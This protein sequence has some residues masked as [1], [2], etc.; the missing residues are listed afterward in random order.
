[1]AGASDCGKVR[2]KNEDRY[3]CDTA[4]QFGILCDGVGGARGGNI[5]AGLAVD[6]LRATLR[7]P[8]NHTA[9]KLRECALAANQGIITRAAQDSHLQ[10]MATT[11]VAFVLAD[12]DVHILHVGDSRAYL[13]SGRTGSLQQLTRDHS[14][15]NLVAIGD[16]PKEAL[17]LQTPRALASYLG[18]EDL[19]RIDILRFKLAPDDMLL[20]SSDGLFNMVPDHEI[21]RILGSHPDDLETI[22]ENLIE[23][24]NQQGGRDNITVILSQWQNS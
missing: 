6:A 8:E 5:A 1:M 9:H 24:A 16:L 3:Y 11:L 14:V 4:N 17:D 19:T 2:S 13:Y 21:A 22:V 10:G 12:Q 7:E 15:E 20:C 18:K 23:A